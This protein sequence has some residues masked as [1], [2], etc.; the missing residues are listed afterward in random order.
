MFHTCNPGPLL[1]EWMS[2]DGWNG[3]HTSLIRIARKQTSQYLNKCPQWIKAR[4][5]IP[6]LECS[7]ESLLYKK[8]KLMHN[9]QVVEKMKKKILH[10]FVYC[11]SGCLYFMKKAGWEK[12]QSDEENNVSDIWKPL[13]KCWFPSF[14]SLLKGAYSI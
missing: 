4:T 1:D 5:V 14:L 13:S 10:W 8:G 6:K 2:V 3:K 11:R 9:F 7:P 12:R